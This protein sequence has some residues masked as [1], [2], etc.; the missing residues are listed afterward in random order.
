MRSSPVAIV[1][2]GCVTP[3]G[4]GVDATFAALLAGR[5]GVRR[6]EGETPSG[7]ASLAA[8]VDAPYLRREVPRALEPQIKFLNGAGQLAVE[9]VE[10]AWEPWRDD[11]VA[12]D[13]KGLFLSQMD[14]WDWSCVELR[15]GFAEATGEFSQ[16]A[17]GEGL[18]REVAR[19]T[20]PFFLLE[21]LK[22]NAFSFLANLHELKGANTS[23]AG[24]S[25]ASLAALDFAARA[26]GRGDLDRA[27][28]VGAGRAVH[29]VARA[30]VARHGLRRAGDDAA[31]RPFDREGLG[32]V[33]GEAAAALALERV[34]DAQ[35][36]GRRIL[37]R[38]RGTGA[39]IDAPR[40][41]LPVPRA[42]AYADALAHALAA[43]G[44]EAA[45]VGFLV[46]PATGRPEADAEVLEACRA[47]DGLADVPQVSWRG[48]FGN[49]PLA[50]E[51]VDLVAATRAL[52]AG[53]V[54][55][56][57][58]LERGLDGAEGV[59]R[60]AFA[61][62]RRLALVLTAGLGGGAAAVVVGA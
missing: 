2:T 59:R 52:A 7:P 18:N 61:P 34:E 40:D 23:V 42:A 15:A 35:A 27:L 47:V 44:A 9:A 37:A 29:G 4:F 8:V 12:G 19:R 43:A 45:E 62:E 13:R 53:T 39:G 51:L 28:V 31:F 58:G 20:K 56:T 5:S 21:S 33:R 54:P 41:D 57:V 50:G 30:D 6:L 49:T 1:G 14:A 26:L 48:A 16:D 10:E 25:G 17:P 36:A 32:E 24:W 22:N 60:E 11:E 38:L 55:G 46:L 3:L